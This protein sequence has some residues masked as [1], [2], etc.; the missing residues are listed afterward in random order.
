MNT[1][2]KTIIC[3]LCASLVLCLPLTAFA[4][5]AAPETTAE[6]APSVW[7]NVRVSCFANGLS[8]SQTNGSQ[9]GVFGG[10]YAYR[11][12]NDTYPYLT[13][14]FDST[15]GE[16]ALQYS[17]SISRAVLVLSGADVTAV[18][19]GTYEV[20]TKESLV[21]E[22]GYFAN[23][24]PLRASDGTSYTVP[25]SEM[26]D[27]VTYV[28]LRPGTETNRLTVTLV[29]TFVPSSP[30]FGQT[31]GLVSTVTSE[32]VL[33]GNGLIAFVSSNWI[34]LLSLALWLGVIVTV[35]VL[36]FTK[37]S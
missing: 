23:G 2:L 22:G 36:K 6:P 21:A 7:D 13:S 33:W 4:S 5:T 17:S 24:M 11:Y 29:S 20:V 16:L 18:S 35:V 37:G 34:M 1:K 15:S 14:S 9:Y 25:V 10:A 27:N 31:L 30:G 32:F 8:N 19:V 28:L 12:W 26:P 3:V